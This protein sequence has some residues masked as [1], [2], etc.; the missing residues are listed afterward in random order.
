MRPPSVSRKLRTAPIRS[1][2]ASSSIALEATAGCQR[3]WPL[4]SRSNAQTSSSGAATIVLRRTS[5]MPSAGE[6][7]LQRIQTRGEDLAADILDQRILAV[8]RGVEFGAP[9]GE[10]VIVLR[11]R[12]EPQGRQ[13]VLDAHRAFEN[14]I[15]TGHLI[16]GQREQ[17]LANA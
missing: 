8:G 17:P 6:P 4:K 9:F 5:T 3:S 12:Y 15:H 14:R 11:D 13:I 16:V 1:P 2:S 7:G 10:G